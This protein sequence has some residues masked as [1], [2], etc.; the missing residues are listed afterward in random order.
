MLKVGRITGQSLKIKAGAEMNHESPDL[1]AAPVLGER[2]E[3]SRRLREEPW[4]DV[5]LARDRLL[6]AEVGLKVLP[7]EAPEWAA[8]Q[9]YLRAGGRPGLEAAPSQDPGGL[10]PGA[11]R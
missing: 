3:I 8:A 6:G 9:G 1:P 2:Y 5:W 10:S 7:R 11:H 4:G